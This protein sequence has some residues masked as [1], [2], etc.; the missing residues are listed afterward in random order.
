MHAGI[1]G[2]TISYSIVRMVTFEWY[3]KMKYNVDDAL[4]AA[5][6]KSILVEVNTIGSTPTLLSTACFTL[7]GAVTGFG[8][9][10][11]ACKSCRSIVRA[12]CTHIK[13]HGEEQVRLN[14]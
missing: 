9:S 7:A 12:V 3:A 13:A 11:L 1:V 14:C 4:M 8:V 5:T 10:F 2:P 6:G